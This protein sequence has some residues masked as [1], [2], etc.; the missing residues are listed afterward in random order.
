MKHKFINARNL[1]IAL[2]IITLLMVGVFFV[3]NRKIN[4]LHMA[5]EHLQQSI[6]EKGDVIEFRGALGDE[7]KGYIIVGSDGGV[8]VFFGGSEEDGPALVDA[9]SKYSQVVDNWYLK[10]D[11]KGAYEYCREQGIAVSHVFLL[12]GVEEVTQ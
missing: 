6:T 3:L 8:N 5:T 10:E 2:L 4:N 7:W 1:S 9:I 12:Q 11:E